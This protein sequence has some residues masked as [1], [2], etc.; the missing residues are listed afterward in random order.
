MSLIGRNGL[1]VAILPIGD[2][3]TMGPED[4]LLALDFLKPKA[5]I[6]CHYGTW[7]PIAVDVEAWAAQVRAETAVNPVI[8]EVEGSYT[9]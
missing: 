9:L 4:A 5:V 7:P 1:D 8:L 2:N 6:P 3:F